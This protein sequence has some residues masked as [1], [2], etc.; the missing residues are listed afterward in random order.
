VPLHLQPWWLDAVCGPDNWGVCLARDDG[1][2]I[3]GVLPW[4]RTR[5]FGLSVILQ[6]PFTSYGGP[7]FQYPHNPDFK[8]ASRYAFEKKTCTA[9]ISQLPKTAVFKQTFRPEITNHLPF[10]W[11]GFRQTTRYTYII[12]DTR[13]TAGIVSEFRHT[14]RT[15]LNKAEAATQIFREDDQ[16]ALVLALNRQSFSRKGKKQP[17]NPD[18]FQ[19]LHAVLQERRQLACFVARDRQ[20]NDPHAALYLVF[21][22]RQA[23]ILLTGTAS[24]YKTQCG[25]FGL[26]LEAI[27]FCGERALSLD[28]EGSMDP[29]IEHSFRAFGAR[30]TPYHQIWKY[31]SLWLESFETWRR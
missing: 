16:A 25:I 31:N 20:N 7:W 17:Y 14:L 4:Y 18:I 30:L 5:R 6:P 12:E 11:Q 19:K 13:D 22:E 2:N 27:R 24:N 29:A 3:T 8:R 1:G 9:L 21:D 26:F 10:H 23:A 28:F 15:D